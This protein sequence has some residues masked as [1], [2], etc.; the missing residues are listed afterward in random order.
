MSAGSTAAPVWTQEAGSSGTRLAE[1]LVVWF[2]ASCAILFVVSA[3]LQIAV[4]L[5]RPQLSEIMGA[6]VVYSTADR[7]IGVREP[8]Q[9]KRPSLLQEEHLTFERLAERHL[10]L[11]RERTTVGVLRTGQG[12][13]QFLSWARSAVLRQH[14]WLRVAT[15]RVLSLPQRVAVLC[16]LLSCALLSSAVF[17]HPDM[18]PVRSTAGFGRSDTALRYLA[19]L[20]LRAAGCALVT[21][22]AARVA[23]FF[24][25][26]ATRAVFASGDDDQDYELPGSEGDDEPFGQFTAFDEGPAWGE[27]EQQ[28][29]AEQDATEAEAMA[30]AALAEAAAAGPLPPEEPPEEPPGPDLLSVAPI[31]PP[32]EDASIPTDSATLASLYAGAD[33]LSERSTAT[34]L[35]AVGADDVVSSHGQHSMP[36]PL[37][38]PPPRPAPPR[39]RAR[40]LRRPLC[41]PASWQPR[42]LVA[43]YAQ[44][45]MPPPLSGSHSDRS[46][47]RTPAPA[48]AAPPEAHPFSP[49]SD[50]QRSRGTP[51]PPRRT[52]NPLERTTHDAVT[53][54]EQE[55]EAAPL[56]PAEE[57]ASSQ[58]P[59]T[60]AKSAAPLPPQP[61]GPDGPPGG[62]PGDTGVHAHAYGAHDARLREGY[63]GEGSVPLRRTSLPDPVEG[64]MTAH[65]RQGRAGV[66]WDAPGE[67]PALGDTLGMLNVTLSP[68]EGFDMSRVMRG[69]PSD[70]SAG[71]DNLLWFDA[72]R[73]RFELTLLE[74]V[75][76]AHSEDARL[77]FLC[78][79]SVKITAR[80][81]GAGVLPYSPPKHPD[82]RSALRSATYGRGAR[83]P[84]SELSRS[85]G[86]GAFADALMASRGN[87]PRKEAKTSAPLPPGAEQ[88]S[89]PRSARSPRS[90]QPPRSE[91]SSGIDAVPGSMFEGASVEAVLNDPSTTLGRSVLVDAIRAAQRLRP[92]WRLACEAVVLFEFRLAA[93]LFLIDLISQ[94]PDLYTVFIGVSPPQGLRD[95]LLTIVYGRHVG[96]EWARYYAREIWE[97]EDEEDFLQVFDDSQCC[98]EDIEALLFDH[99]VDVAQG[100]QAKAEGDDNAVG[101]AALASGVQGGQRQ[102]QV[103]AH[104]VSLAARRQSGQ[105]QMSRTSSAGVAGNW[106]KY[107]LAPGETTRLVE[108]DGGTMQVESVLAADL[109]A[110]QLLMATTCEN[111]DN[112]FEV[113]EDDYLVWQDGIDAVVDDREFV[114]AAHI[115]RTAEHPQTLDPEF[116]VHTGPSR[117]F[118]RTIEYGRLVCRHYAVHMLDRTPAEFSL[119]YIEEESTR[120]HVP[121]RFFKYPKA[122]AVLWTPDDAPIDTEAAEQL[123]A[124]SPERR[125]T[126]GTV[127]RKSAKEIKKTANTQGMSNKAKSIELVRRRNPYLTYLINHRMPKGTAVNPLFD[128]LPGKKCSN[129]A[130]AIYVK[131]PRESVAHRVRRKRTFTEWICARSGAMPQGT[132]TY[133]CPFVGIEAALPDLKQGDHIILLEGSYPP[134]EVRGLHGTEELPIFISPCGY[135][136]AAEARGWEDGVPLCAERLTDEE[137]QEYDDVVFAR[138]LAQARHLEELVKLIDCS[139]VRIDGC[140]FRNARVGI[141]CSLSRDITVIN[142]VFEQVRTSCLLFDTARMDH[143]VE[144]NLVRFDNHCQRCCHPAA[145]P[146]WAV[147]LGHL[148]CVLLFVASVIGWYEVARAFPSWRDDDWFIG[149][150]LSV[151]IDVVIVEPLFCLVRTCALFAYNNLEPLDEDTWA[152]GEEVYPSHRHSLEWVKRRN[153]MVQDQ[154]WVEMNTA[155]RKYFAALAKENQEREAAAANEAKSADARQKDAARQERVR[156][157]TVG[158]AFP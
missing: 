114:R 104:R 9:V 16:T 75:M 25:E 66:M 70:R 115:F 108:A 110:E 85:Q 90:Q 3:L 139:H 135:R 102:S 130:G 148:S 59:P 42:D 76:V 154:A 97:I 13:R 62:V 149:W 136:A 84:G 60:E 145:L 33:V 47:G 100:A 146:P 155:N 18:D 32:E 63:R 156:K 93:A 38:V 151:A 78:G 29:E 69:G 134:L 45:A 98:P 81:F 83:S 143:T 95:G 111:H 48:P 101:A 65:G 116:P 77:R 7:L 112:L 50:P 86:T 1:E 129:T 36:C 92:V 96:K 118:Y 128:T 35:T 106:K 107:S 124:G 41:P 37:R 34:R 53:S 54:F 14:K 19:D 147:W 39:R 4:V 64:Q 152:P 138:D 8:R 5:R 71:R 91:G 150:G 99:A 133:L 123:D 44:H 137:R 89:S 113:D 117:D 82:D 87:S 141:D 119:Q 142:C 74:M 11:Y 157:S 94:N 68:T 61:A 51:P 28:E 131:A 105:A 73:N 21:R 120:V 56:P 103:D 20:A 72:E 122:E 15:S 10:A 126:S 40:Q 57:A 55:K 153:R 26:N 22:L 12:Y 23:Y 132:G 158:T 2:P 88:K 140:R 121:L 6:P 27:Q 30:E 17:S 43:A 109:A 58:G 31:P 79:L 46:S 144:E 49:A 125:R 80:L 127:R 24:F 52:L 67:E